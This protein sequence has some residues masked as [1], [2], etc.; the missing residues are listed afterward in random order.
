MAQQTFTTA[1][2]LMRARALASRRAVSAAASIS[3]GLAPPSAMLRLSR[4]Q[5]LTTAIAGPAGHDS[6]AS[7]SAIISV[8]AL[9]LCLLHIVWPQ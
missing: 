8:I 3:A 9:G 6:W 5:M 4:I 1:G 7:S 2:C